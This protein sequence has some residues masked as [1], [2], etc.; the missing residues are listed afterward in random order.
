MGN[1]L[2]VTFWDNER[3]TRMTL[4]VMLVITKQPRI[5]N[6]QI[7]DYQLKQNGKKLLVGMKKSR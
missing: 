4:Y 5:A 6:G 3:L 2:H 7:K 1:G